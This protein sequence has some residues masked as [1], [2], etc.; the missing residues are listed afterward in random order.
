M[1]AVGVKELVRSFFYYA[2][3]TITGIHNYLLANIQTG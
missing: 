3:I 1:G 2:F